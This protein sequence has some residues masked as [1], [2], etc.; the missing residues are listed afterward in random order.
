MFN[1]DTRNEASDHEMIHTVATGFKWMTTGEDL[2][3][4]NRRPWEYNCGR[5]GIW[6]LWELKI[7]AVV[8]RIVEAST[9]LA[10]DCIFL[11]SKRKRFGDR[12]QNF[13]NIHF[14]K[15]CARLF[16][17][18]C[19][20]VLFMAFE[21]NTLSYT[22]WLRVYLT[23]LSVYYISFEPSLFYMFACWP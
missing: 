8:L 21:D 10:D 23:F 1:L 7:R 15:K 14:G 16:P 17:R 20:A 12:C 5:A 2:L 3:F 6:I 4:D 11:L 19:R 22:S 18:G 13:Q 9:R